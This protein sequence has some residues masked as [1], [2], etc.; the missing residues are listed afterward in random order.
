MGFTVRLHPPVK[1][2]I[3]RFAPFASVTQAGFVNVVK[4]DWNKEF[5]EELEV[6]DGNG[7]FHDDCADV[8]SDAF[9]ELNRE[10][11]IPSFSL[12]SF[13][14]LG[15]ANSALDIPTSGL[16]IPTSGLSIP[17]Y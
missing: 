10:V 7:K 6:F 11:H 1:S 5:F 8:C 12:E 13:G 17:S 4:A 3:I 16:S 9:F 15:S 14:N 2:K